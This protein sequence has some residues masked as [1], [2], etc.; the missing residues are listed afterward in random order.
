MEQYTKILLSARQK[1]RRIRFKFGLR[2]PRTVQEAYALDKI[3]G[4][5]DWATAIDK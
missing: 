1:S 2:V 5:N 3:E 4:N